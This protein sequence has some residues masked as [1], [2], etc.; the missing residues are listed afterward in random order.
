MSAF[1]EHAAMKLL[2]DIRAESGSELSPMDLWKAVTQKISPSDPFEMVQYLYEQVYKSV[3]DVKPAYIPSATQIANSNIAQYMAR[4]GFATYEDMYEFSVSSATREEFWKDSIDLLD[5]VWRKKP[6]SAF[7]LSQGGAAHVSYLPDGE[8]NIADSCFNKREGHETALVYAME[9]DP[10]SLQHMTFIVLDRLSNQIANAIV[11]KLQFQPG[12]AIGICMPMTPESIAIYLGI[13]KAGCVVVSIADSFSAI[14]IETR[15]RLGEAKA[16]FTQDVIYRGAKFLPLYTRVLEAN[17]ML[18][19]SIQRDMHV[20]VLPGMLHAGPYPKLAAMK[21]SPSGTWDDK[22]EEGV[23][24]EVHASVLEVLRESIDY[25]WHDFLHHCSDEFAAIS[26]KSM[27]PAN[28]LFSSGTTGEPK[29]I[30]WSQST[31]IKCAIDG[32]WHQDV[33]KG[34]TITWPTNIGWMMGP[35]LLFQLISGASI[36]IFNGI[37]ST[38]AFC[39]FVEVAEISMVGVIPSLVKAW[40]ASNATTD[41]DWSKVRRFSSTGEASQAMNMLWLMTR[42]PGCAPVIEYCGGTEIGGSY[43][44]ST[45]VQPNVPS[46]FSS[47]VCGSRITLLDT[48]TSE[49]LPLNTLLPSST[50][51]SI[52]GE[53]A[54]LPPA[55]GLSTTLLN[56]DHYKVYYEDMP[57]SLDGE[58]L[59][60]HG[61]EIEIIKATD[62]K[63]TIEGRDECDDSSIYYRALGRCDDTMN[64][65]GIKISS[66]E[67]ERVCNTTEGVHETAAI[68]YSPP[69]G[70][71]CLLV[72]YVVL[73]D[74]D[75]S[76]DEAALKK[77]MQL[78]IKSKLNPLFGIS[79]IVI[80]DSLPRTASNKVMRR[81]LRD[82]YVKNMTTM[83]N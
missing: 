59:R 79:A 80:S 26:R 60:R 75:T 44:S 57:L 51:C 19:D 39:K 41:C 24:I 31:P 7:D 35:W 34:D 74:K 20:I 65:G 1:E 32:I 55:L 45:I 43:L 8:L 76:V 38:G 40:Q 49:P 71:P 73:L 3:K 11:D 12:D 64:I 69:G 54:L 10:T 37:T 61:D 62:Y 66:V 36:G 25:T 23:P 81:V 47:P 5:I 4:K 16:I 48:G 28:I 63:T 42:V 70:G 18:I 52:S 67:I 21:R 2:D 78:S 58:V 15:C 46:L 72:L 9:S 56:K 27:D 53:V 29:A 13:I 6:S 68:A 50:V 82:E 30:V 14:E 33:Q 77:S 22:D 83:A 17:Q